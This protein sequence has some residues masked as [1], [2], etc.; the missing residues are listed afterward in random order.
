MSDARSRA[1]KLIALAVHPNTPATEASA[2]ALSACRLIDTARLLDAR[3]SVEEAVVARARGKARGFTPDVK[4][5]GSRMTF[6]FGER[7]RQAGSDEEN[8]FFTCETI[9]GQTSFGVP[10]HL[11]KMIVPHTEPGME[12]CILLTVDGGWFA[13]SEVRSYEG[14]YSDE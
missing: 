11:V 8:L 9:Y 7:I 10:R 13:D 12:G 4:A 6:T 3:P 5:R 14:I 2:A 1:R